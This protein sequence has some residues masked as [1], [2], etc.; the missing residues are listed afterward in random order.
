MCD[1]G[2]KPTICCQ[3]KM[4]KSSHTRAIAGRGCPR[5][6]MV[7]VNQPDSP[8]FDGDMVEYSFDF[9]SIVRNIS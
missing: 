5:L 2:R 7:C 4:R 9:A 1:L 3:I 6:P 8:R